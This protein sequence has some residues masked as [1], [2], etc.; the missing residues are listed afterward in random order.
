[1][2]HLENAWSQGGPRAQWPKRAT[3][4]KPVRNEPKKRE[5]HPVQ[6]II[7]PQDGNEVT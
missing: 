5:K 1:M 2:W 6:N 7:L 3:A 4:L